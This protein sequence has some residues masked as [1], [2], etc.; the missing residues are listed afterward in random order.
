M[1]SVTRR[2]AD[3]VPIRACGKFLFRGEEKFYARGVTYGP[4]MPQA[5]SMFGTRAQVERDF[6]LM[7]KA[8]I[9]T[10]RTYTVP[11]RWLLD[12]ASEHDLSV[13]VGIAWPQHVAFLKSAVES[14][15]I[16]SVEQ[17][18]LA[19]QNHPAV[20]AYC[21]GNEI[22]AAVIRWH[23]PANVERFLCKLAATVRAGD[24]LKLVTYANFPTT[25]YLDLSFL[26]V[27]CFNI[28]LEDGRDFDRYLNRL[29]NIADARPVIISELGIDSLRHGEL[30]QAELIGSQ[31]Q[32]SFLS[33]CSGTFVFAWTDEWYTGDHDVADWQFGL[34]SRSRV[35]KPALS[36]VRQVYKDVLP[37]GAVTPTVSIVVC[38]YNGEATLDS[39]LRGTEKLDYPDY[40]VIVVDDGSTDQTAAIAARYDV[41][42]VRTKNNGLAS[43]RNTGLKHARGKI[44]VYLDDDAWPDQHWLKHLV[45]M[46]ETDDVV[47]VGGPNIPPPNESST[48]TCVANAPGGPMH[49]LVSDREAEHIP[50]CNMAFCAN[51]LRKIGGFDER[52]RV[53]GDDVDIC[54]RIQNEGWRI[55]FHP[56]AVVWHKRRNSIRRFLKQQAGYGKAEALL[57][58]KWPQRY[59][60][61]GHLTWSGRIYGASVAEARWWRRW[62]IYYGTW[63][64]AS[65]QS[66]RHRQRV[67]AGLALLPEWY[68]VIT[69][70]AGFSALGLV[71]KP[72][73][74]VVPLTVAALLALI[75][76]A[77]F[78]ALRATFTPTATRRQQVRW[79]GVVFALYLLQ[80]LARLTGRA[81]AGLVPWRRP[82]VSIKRLPWRR[83]TWFE[84]KQ[85]CSVQERLALLEGAIYAI[86]APAIRAGV[87]D[88]WD[89]EVRVGLFG[90]ARVL[91][92]VEEHGFGAQVV[93]YRYWPVAG[94]LGIAMAGGFAVTAGL[95]A[96]TGSAII[97]YVFG[98]LA[99][100]FFCW[101]IIDCATASEILRIAISADSRPQPQSVDAIGEGDSDSIRVHAIGRRAV[102]GHSDEQ[103]ESADRVRHEVTTR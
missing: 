64:S 1:R 21:I 34:V 48:A 70:L 18:V 87:H 99:V 75:S 13:M 59:N 25:E 103:Y 74:L 88:R 86:G 46:F 69:L 30:R 84:T 65:F 8:G 98:G 28:F 52:F 9:N 42:L 51:S 15:I 3:V 22:P 12:M 92:A 5:G 37:T 73:L 72:L 68:L 14:S 27:V 91:T 36:V 6:S 95:A 56:A 16:G 39:C 94:R 97:G 19:C 100:A 33:G 40:E 67:F 85:W 62:K 55:G 24:P 32:S 80:P 47:A 45:H 29:H 50:G 93:R 63:G 26:D 71:W 77:G 58:R 76:Q 83:E 90:A 101:L 4:F 78:G 102:A 49:V 54:W 66:T 17:A 60:R 44:V 20:F 79:R 23:G 31:L 35:E 81:C 2:Q 61:G 10:V 7:A 38:T 57:E 11:P 96:G 82:I 43:A 89:L 41:R 53:A